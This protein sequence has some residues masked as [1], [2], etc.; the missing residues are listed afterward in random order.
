MKRL[1]LILIFSFLAFTLYTCSKDEN[2]LNPPNNDINISIT[3][4]SHYSARQ[5]EKVI[6]FGQ[7][8]NSYDLLYVELN[9]E[10]VE[11]NKTS[12]STISLF[13]PYNGSNG[14]FVFYFYAQNHNTVLT[15]PIITITDYCISDL[16][17][18]L[19]TKDRI[20]ESD[21][22]I[23]SFDIDTLKWT[24][25]SSGDTLFFT[26]NGFCH[27]ECGFWHTVA[28]M[29]KQNN[30]LPEFLYSIYKKREWF[31]PNVDDTL[32]N[33]VIRID[34]WDSTSVYSG[35]FSFGNYNWIF[36]INI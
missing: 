31:V 36:W 8:L 17:F 9:D 1:I 4:L 14:Q 24:L 28:F 27:D 20:V 29:K 30:G 15:S 16:C 2:I 7:N 19:N 11:F 26:R 12:D 34:Q 33:G 13:I 3:T 22:W 21:S 32:R 6:A 5:G 18:D 35:T 10:A 25:E 23:R